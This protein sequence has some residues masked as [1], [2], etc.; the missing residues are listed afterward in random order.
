MMTDEN[1]KDVI[2]EL[3]KSH[4][5]IFIFLILFVLTGFLFSGNRVQAQDVDLGDFVRIGIGGR[6][7]A[8][9][10]AYVAVGGNSST[11]FWNPAGLTELESLNFGGMYTDRFSAGIIYQYLS[12][13]GTFEFKALEDEPD[14]QSGLFS[15]LARYNPIRGT[16]GLN[17]TRIGMDVGNVSYA[18]DPVGES[19]SLW[20][21]AAGYE[22]P[23]E[24]ILKGL[25][26]GASLKRYRRQLNE[27]VVSGWG[28]DLGMTYETGLSPTNLPISGSVGFVLQDPGGVELK[29]R[30]GPDLETS[31]VIPAYN[32]L[33]VAVTVHASVPVTV[34]A[35]YDFSPARPQLNRV[36]LATEVSFVDILHLRGGLNKWLREEGI[37]FS[38][39][40]GVDIGFFNVNYAYLPHNLGSTHIISSDF[41]F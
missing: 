37:G 15:N 28:Y 5:L 10:G 26:L 29:P 39:G 13:S 41:S 17:L 2:H 40:A 9:S 21:G 35:Q 34:G 27:D 6:P 33:G 8:M 36:S 32:R 16:I 18:N 20:L 38:V 23:E 25:S 11:G 14:E 7:L 30:D 19:R 24:T 31:G 12:G 4:L 22:F 3:R 1:P